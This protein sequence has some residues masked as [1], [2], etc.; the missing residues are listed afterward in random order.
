MP[1]PDALLQAIR[2]EFAVEFTRHEAAE[3]S[4]LLDVHRS[5]LERLQ[6]MD[7]TAAMVVW[8]RL[9]RLA[10]RSL[11]P[12]YDIGEVPALPFEQYIPPVP[13]EH[14]WAQSY[15]G[16]LA[17]VLL[18]YMRGEIDASVIA[19]FMMF[20]W[21]EDD[22]VLTAIT[23]SLTDV[24]DPYAGATLTISTEQWAWLQRLLAALL[25][26]LPLEVVRYEGYG[27]SNPPP[28]AAFEP[29]GNLEQFQMHEHVLRDL[30]ILDAAPEPTG[31]HNVAWLLVATL[32]IALAGVGGLIVASPI[33]FLVGVVPLAV[34]VCLLIDARRRRR[35][36]ANPESAP[37]PE[38]VA[39]MVASA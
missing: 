32:V 7:T 14:D 15:R 38:Y 9:L 16:Q 30:R 26:D 19:G 18:A 34:V 10:R 37:A 33:W 36:A 29:F 21:E 17:Q 27:A 28:D 12:R 25:L 8:R 20:L 3:L 5:L 4:S 31:G 35:D 24:I 23:N 6:I 1:A 22:P 39:V 13:Q 2:S 11:K